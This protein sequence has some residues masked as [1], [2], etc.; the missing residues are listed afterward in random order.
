[1][2]KPTITQTYDFALTEDDIMILRYA[3]GYMH[4][5]EQSARTMAASARLIAVFE[6]ELMN[7]GEEKVSPRIAKKKNSG[8]DPQ[9]EVE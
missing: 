1:M 4:D 6:D 9:E 5:G 8:R 2:T 3:L 7:I